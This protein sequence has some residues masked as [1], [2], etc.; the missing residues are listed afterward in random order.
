[1]TTGSPLSLILRF[2][3][4]LVA[5]SMLQQVFSLTDTMVLGVFA[6]NQAIAVL[7]VCLWPVWLQVSVLTNLGQAACL[8]AAVRFGAKDEA[9]LR[10]AVGCVYRTAV[11]VGLLFIPALILLTKP[12]RSRS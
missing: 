6:G 3:L 1:M 11:W 7:G 12:F 4:P 10:R 2:A 8:L 9:A 5:A